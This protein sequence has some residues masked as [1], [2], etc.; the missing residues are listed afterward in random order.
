[1]TL[2][3][4]QGAG[5]LEGTHVADRLESGTRR[6]IIVLHLPAVGGFLCQGLRVPQEV[7]A[8]SMKHRDI[9]GLEV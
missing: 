1:M 9:E 2:R 5:G 6:I 8:P 7:T 3:C 4:V